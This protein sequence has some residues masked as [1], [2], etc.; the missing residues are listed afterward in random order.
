M[1][2]KILDREVIKKI[3]LHGIITCIFFI[4]PQRAHAVTTTF[5]APSSISNESFF[6]SISITGA[7]AGINYLKAD[8][9]KDGSTNY[10]G[11]TYNNSEWYKGSDGT[12][13][14]PITIK[15]GTIGQ[16]QL[17]VQLGNPTLNEYDGQGQY[18]IRVRRYTESGKYTSSEANANATDI[19]INVLLSTPTPTIA[20]TI[21]PFA[22]TSQPTLTPVPTT[23]IP[24]SHNNILISEVM[25]YPKDNNEEWIELYNNNDFTVSL[26]NWYI[27]DGENTGSSPKL[28]SISIAPK[29]YIVI[30]LT[31]WLF[32]NDGDAVRVLD[33]NKT[34][35]DSFAYPTTKKGK[36]YG[37]VSFPSNDFCQQNQTKGASNSGCIESE[38]EKNL[39]P[40]PSQSPAP[41]PTPTIAP[42]Q[43][44]ETTTTFSLY[45]TKII[46]D[47]VPDIVGTIFS[48]TQSLPSHGSVLSAE[49]EYDK[50]QRQRKAKAYVLGLSSS[51]ALISL[52]NIS[53][54]VRK[55]I[56]R[57]TL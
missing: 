42:F 45:Q 17:Q 10:F 9:Y 48:D 36:T 24:V 28:F 51:S 26:D 5:T 41:T 15:S 3:I 12:K 33:S 20:P 50:V 34:E 25:P 40:T 14:F 30:E 2:Q 46:V 19:T 32:N 55:I 11:E 43:S 47:S 53:V 21:T 38:P 1:K 37:R 8:L 39:T 13:Y 44:P 49:T 18:K 52:L 16:D 56:Q 54:I 29:Q 22:E 27:D 23:T 35:K 57:L 7:S 31:S 4:L 6:L